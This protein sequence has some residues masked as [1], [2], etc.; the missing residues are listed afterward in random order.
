MSFVCPRCTVPKL[1]ITLGIELPPDKRADEITLQ[2][3]ECSVCGW[4]GLGVYREYKRGMQ[5][6]NE[7]FEHIG[8]HLPDGEYRMVRRLLSR[9]PSRRN[10]FCDCMV[11][12]M[13]GHRD[14]DGNWDGLN[15]IRTHES[16]QLR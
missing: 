3:L 5:V 12:R 6:G 16:F 7:R 15:T 9:C 10:P 14:L 2:L 4:T 13:L 1:N 11:H 8:Y